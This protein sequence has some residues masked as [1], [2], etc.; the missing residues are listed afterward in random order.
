[1]DIHWKTA[2][3]AVAA[4][5][6]MAAASSE[7]TVRAKINLSPTA[8]A[9][10]GKGKASAVLKSSS[11]GRFD[12][13]VKRLE[14]DT[15]YDLVVAGI[16]VATIQTNRRG[17]G[18]ARFSTSPRGRRTFL[19]FDPRGE[20]IE[21]RSPSGDD[22]LVGNLPTAGDDPTDLTCCIPD[23]NGAQCEDRTQAECD[24]AGGTVVT[25]S[26]CLPDPCGGTP[27]P[28]TDALCC[29]PNDTG[30]ECED[31]TQASCT[32]AGGTLVEATSC[33]PNPCQAAPPPPDADIQCC[34][35]AYYVFACEDRTVAECELLGGLN[36]GSGSCSPNPCGDL[37]PPA[38]HGICCL[39]NAAG[40]EI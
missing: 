31:R 27:P 1:M 29:I 13:R 24:A 9:P 5:G 11:E 7:A 10:D 33:D 22:V 40:D 6:L 21:I 15:A 34:I 30:P 16:K 38:D 23:D 32:A 20:S 36:K 39:P 2:I 19:G 17:K 12:I 8:S 35:P 4:I 25:A 14:P 28:E 26:S 18:R 3:A 37:P